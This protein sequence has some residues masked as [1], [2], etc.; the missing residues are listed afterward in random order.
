MLSKINIFIVLVIITTLSC[1]K[2]PRLKVNKPEIEDLDSL[3]L[4]LDT[5]EKK[6][7]FLIDLHDKDQD[8]RNSDREHEILK[9]NN[10]NTQSQQYQEFVERCIYTDA[11]NF[12]KI[13]KYLEIHRYPIF[14]PKHDNSI[15]AIRLICLHQSFDKQLEL[16]PYLYKAYNDGFINSE[17]F[18]FLLNKMHIMKYG[19]SHPH[20][21]SY[22]ENVEQLLEKLQLK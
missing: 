10:Y 2:E 13:K 20:A 11:I 3:I 4:S 19:E 18:S 14:K 9:R 15:S 6:E 5:Q 12:K 7:Q 1:N 16:F 21:I 17:R 8:V 22:E